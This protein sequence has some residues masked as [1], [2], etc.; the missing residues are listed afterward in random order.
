[1]DKT[2]DRIVNRFD[3]ARIAK[4]TV[5]PLIAVYQRPTDYPDKY[6]ARLWDA[7]RPTN[8]VALA[9][10]YDGILETIPTGQMVSMGRGEKDDPAIVEVWI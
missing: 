3:Y 6:V 5:I 1:M 9:D 10:D 4:A 2:T 7:G 8:T